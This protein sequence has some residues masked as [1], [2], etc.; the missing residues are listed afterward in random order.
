M[1]DCVNVNSIAP[2]QLTSY[3]SKSIGMKSG[4]SEG[5]VF[6]V[7]ET[8]E[9]KEQKDSSTLYKELSGRYDVR[10]STFGEIVEM[11][12]ALYGAGKISLSEHAALTFDYDRA[13][14]NIKRHASG[15]ISG[16]F[17]LHETF[18]NSDG[19]RDWIAEFE[20]RASKNFKFGNLLGYESDKRVLD[21]LNRLSR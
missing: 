13:T 18:A 19:Q 3:Y 1:V 15:Y 2:H 6:I 17:N 11:S 16:D 14:D 9:N 12:G 4:N 20:A 21:I 10:N 7:G 5:S 8:V